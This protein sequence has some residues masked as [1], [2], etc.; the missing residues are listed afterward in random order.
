MEQ[1]FDKIKNT[2]LYEKSHQNANVA[3]EKGKSLFDWAYA[4]FLFAI[5]ELSTLYHILLQPIKGKTHKE[6][7]DSFYNTVSS[8]YYD[9]FRQRLLHGRERMLELALEKAQKTTSNKLVWV[10]LGSGTGNNIEF[11]QRYC[12]DGDLR[13]NFSKI[14]LVDLSSNL[15]NVARERVRNLKLEDLVEVVE[16]DATTYSLPEKARADLVTFSYSLTMIPDWFSAIEQGARLLKKG[17]IISVVDF[18]VSRK[19]AKEGEVQHNWFV[20]WFWRAYF[21]FDNVYLSD[22]HLPYLDA[23]FTRQELQENMG[24]IP[25]ITFLTL[26]KLKTPHYIYVGARA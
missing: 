11:M 4:L 16:H 14:Y 2:Q 7:L 9:K 13:K 1:V 24:S 26:G 21:A 17:G 22:D 23:H 5:A 3:Y 8:L 12:Q 25:Y 15:C 6:R 19:W 20:R 18:Y 10:D